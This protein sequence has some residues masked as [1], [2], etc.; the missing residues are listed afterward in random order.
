MKTI[1]DRQ[2][3]SIDGKER[4][5]AVSPSPTFVGRN[6]SIRDN[7]EAGMATVEFALIAMFVVLP[8]LLGIMELGRLFYVV[9]TSQEI[10]RRAARQQVVSWID[11]SSAI[12]RFSVFREAGSGSVA[13]PGGVEIQSKD[14]RL[15]FYGSYADAISGNNPIS[16]GSPATNITNCIKSSGSC[17][18]FVRASLESARGNNVSYLPMTGLFDTLLAVPLPNATVIMPAEALGVL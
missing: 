5:I 3:S 16:G 11:Q 8:L 10:T 14:V 9:T 7:R 2:P 6:R 4:N 18:R 1:V 15:D 13:L 12:Q 17:I